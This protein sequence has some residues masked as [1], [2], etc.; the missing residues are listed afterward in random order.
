[1]DGRKL[2]KKRILRPKLRKKLV[3]LIYIIGWSVGSWSFVGWWVGSGCNVG[4]F[5]VIGDILGIFDGNIDG[6]IDDNMHHI[7][8]Q[9][10]DSNQTPLFASVGYLPDSERLELVQLLLNY[11]M[12]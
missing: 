8:Y 12:T 4:K 9:T 1:M 3:F 7:L 2:N 5:V 11:Y 6:N 10:N